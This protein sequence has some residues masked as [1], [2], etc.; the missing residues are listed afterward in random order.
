MEVKNGKTFRRTKNNNYAGDIL[1][2]YSDGKGGYHS[3][4]SHY[5]FEKPEMI[6][7]CGQRAK[8]TC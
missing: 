1:I 7:S 2:N 4:F 3:S 5:L 6:Y 8:R